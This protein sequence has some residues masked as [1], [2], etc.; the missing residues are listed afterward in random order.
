MPRMRFLLAD[1]RTGGW[2][3]APGLWWKQ[4]LNRE[5]RKYGGRYG[6]CGQSTRVPLRC[7]PTAM[8]SEGVAHAPRPPPPPGAS[9][10]RP[11]FEPGLGGGE[12]RGKAAARRWGRR[13]GFPH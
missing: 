9:S 2:K 6:P 13:G 8:A 12:E 7:L 5:R 10:P 4:K 3:G 11:L 1:R